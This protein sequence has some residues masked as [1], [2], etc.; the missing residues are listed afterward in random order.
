[1]NLSHE[2]EAPQFPEPGD[3]LP[4]DFSGECPEVPVAGPRPLGMFPTPVSPGTM[5]PLRVDLGAGRPPSADTAE[6]PGVRGAGSLVWVTPQPHRYPEN[7]T[8]K[9]KPTRA[10]PGVAPTGDVSIESGIEL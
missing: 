4:S 3:W 1:M 6:V 9:K 5:T 8:D 10:G 7:A 2:P